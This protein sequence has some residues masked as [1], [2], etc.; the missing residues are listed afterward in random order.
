MALSPLLPIIA[1][2]CLQFIVTYN[3]FLF[4]DNTLFD[5]KSL[6]L[7]NYVR[8]EKFVNKL[9]NRHN[10][11]NKKKLATISLL[12]MVCH[13]CIFLYQTLHYNIDLHTTKM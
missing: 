7:Q 10:Q 1:T 11:K 4:S 6:M 13:F 12:L 9:A 8:Y 2:R 5:L 3:L